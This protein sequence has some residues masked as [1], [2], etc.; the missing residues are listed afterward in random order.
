MY[1]TQNTKHKIVLRSVQNKNSNYTGSQIHIPYIHPGY[2][3]GEK[4]T[5]FSQLNNRYIN[6]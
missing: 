6:K 3:G 1:K 4:V 2:G 5:Q